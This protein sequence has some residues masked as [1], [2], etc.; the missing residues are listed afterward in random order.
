MSSAASQADVA[1][2]GGGIVGLAT[3]ASLLERRPGSILVLEAEDRIAAHQTGHS[4]G[5]VHSG[6]YYA[7]G[8]L[9]ARLCVEGRRS[10]EHYCAE[11]GVRFER[12]GK[13]V[14]A[15]TP[16]EA[17]RLDELEQRGRAN[18]LVGLERLDRSG[19]REREPH[20]EALAGL[21]VP[22]TGIVDFPGVAEA[23]AAD[24][25]ARGGEVRT[26]ARLVGVR[27]EAGG[28]VLETGRGAVRA[29]AIVACAGLHADRVARRCGLEPGVRIVPFRGE[30]LEVAPERRALVRHLVYP[31]PDPR[32]PFLGVHLTR[33]VSGAVEAGPN[34]ILALAREGYRRSDLSIR[35]CAEMFSYPGLWR[36]IGRLGARGLVELRRG[37]DRGALARAARRL[38]PELAAGDFRPGGAGVRAQALSPDGRLVDDFHLVEAERMVHVLNAPSPAATASLAIGRWI[39]DRAATRFG[40]SA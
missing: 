24:V 9:K 13:V 33:M 6:L 26:G 4:S 39:A 38:V 28:L 22:E 20:V 15:V 21:L 30:Y 31:V 23:L 25:R 19:L 12:C 27:R 16:A 18:G 11:R 35:D 3:A 29:R 32:F 2:I 14:V 7:P 8:S 5:V 1:V 36:M 17:A 40:W 10:L 34:A 37:L